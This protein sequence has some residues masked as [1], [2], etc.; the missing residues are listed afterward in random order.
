[1][2]SLEKVHKIVKWADAKQGDHIEVIHVSD[3]TSITDY[4]VIC[5]GNSKIQLKAIADEIELKLKEEHNVRPSHIEGYNTD[6]WILLDYLDVVVHIFH[7]E[8]RLF[9]NLERLW[10]DAKRVPLESILGEGNKEE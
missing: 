4:F 10:A 5:S 7:R 9:Y 6:S 1:M 3:V 2:N 8:S